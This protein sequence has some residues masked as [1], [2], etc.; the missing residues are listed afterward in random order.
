MRTWIAAGVV[1]GVSTV[2]VAA[3]PQLTDS[4]RSLVTAAER[5]SPHAQYGVGFLYLFG[6]MGA[7]KDYMTA[8]RWLQRAAEQDHLV[9]QFFLGLLYDTGQGVPQDHAIA[10][11]W[12]QRAADQG[13]AE[14]QLNLG[15]LYNAGRGIPQDYVTAHMWLNLAAAQRTS[16]LTDAAATARRRRD[17]LAARMTPE[18]IAE[19][20]RR[21]RE[22]TPTYV[23]MELCGP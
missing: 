9:A 12:Y 20:Q 7:P 5:G 1:A 16:P 17:L 19:A 6:R 18:Q 11:Q 21:A 3:E 13:Y 15:A 8:A 2:A 10:A 23:M 4:G 14:A 22:W